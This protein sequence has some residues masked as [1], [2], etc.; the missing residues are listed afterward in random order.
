MKVDRANAKAID[1]TKAKDKDE[2]EVVEHGKAEI[3]LKWNILRSRF[4]NASCIII[5]SSIS[6]N[7]LAENLRSLSRPRRIMRKAIARLPRIKWGLRFILRVIFLFLTSWTFHIPW[8]HYIWKIPCLH[9]FYHLYH[10]YHYNHCVYPSPGCKQGREDHAQGDRRLEENQQARWRE[11]NLRDI[12][13]PGS[14]VNLRNMS[15]WETCQPGSLAY[16]GEGQE[17]DS[18][19]GDDVHANR[20][21]CAE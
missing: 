18:I 17:G 21:V 4:V 15:T 5:I 7:H 8:K 10:C 16:P 9:C 14:H 12:R 11:I 1:E 6:I 13:Q 3:G 2:R 19:I 20:G